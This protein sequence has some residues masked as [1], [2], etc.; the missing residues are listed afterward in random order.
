MGKTFRKEQKWKKEK[1]IR[2]REKR[3][4][5]R[6]VDDKPQERREKQEVN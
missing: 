6:T 2:L 4:N 5:T 1:S 3:L